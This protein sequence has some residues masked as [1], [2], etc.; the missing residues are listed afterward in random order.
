MFLILLK[1]VRGI[2]RVEQHVEAHRAFLDKYYSLH[3]FICSGAQVPRLGG[4]ILCKADSRDE[5][6]QIIA[7][8][9]F[10]QNG[11]AEYEVI[12]FTPSKY[13]PAFEAFTF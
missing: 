4:V 3:R 12:E 8:D 1:Y 10:Y 11:A 6:W 13:S 5:I 9:P 2:E 7:E